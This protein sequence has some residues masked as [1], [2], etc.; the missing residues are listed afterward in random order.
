MGR[1][2]RPGAGGHGGLT[3]FDHVQWLSEAMRREG[4]VW[5]NG[6]NVSVNAT[7]R[8]R[9]TSRR[10][11]CLAHQ[12]GR[13]LLIDIWPRWTTGDGFSTL[14]GRGGGA[15]TDLARQLFRDGDEGPDAAIEAVESAFA[16]GG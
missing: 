6:P 13:F 15:R 7:V 4:L 14:P 5:E 1:R 2:L 3:E 9:T 8:T 16:R 12:R 11:R 10:R